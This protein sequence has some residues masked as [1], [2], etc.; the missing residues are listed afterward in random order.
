MSGH[1]KW[2]T[3]KRAKEVTDAK[4][5][6]IFT[7][8]ARAISVAAKTGGDPAMN[9][10]LRVAIDKAREA[11]MPKDNIERAIKKGTGEEKGE[12]L[13]EILYEGF[14]SGGVAVLVE[15]VTDN[16]NRAASNL[17]HIFQKHGGSLGSTNSVLWQ[18]E[19]RG[20]FFIKT[21]Q[22]EEIE[23]NLIE[24]GVE[25]FEPTENGYACFCAPAQ[26]HEIA[27]NLLT[28]NLI[29]T[30]LSAHFIPKETVPLTPEITS[31][32]EELENDDDVNTVTANYET[33]L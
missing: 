6:N 7:K 25:D 29:A 31:L 9:S 16:K 20:V 26:L 19:R 14:G 28:Y 12:A 22:S 15:V 30:E 33:R 13:E 11:N 21:K 24:A 3:I 18:F 1:S 10:S 17:R 4:R 8:L 2:A 5:G 27:K 32:I 23:L